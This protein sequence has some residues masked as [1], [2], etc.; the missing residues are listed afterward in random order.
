MQFEAGHPLLAEVDSSLGAV[1]A[2]IAV[3]LGVVAVLA[4]AV[5]VLT[6]SAVGGRST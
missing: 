1:I 3:V 2:V 4:F 6:S 5:H